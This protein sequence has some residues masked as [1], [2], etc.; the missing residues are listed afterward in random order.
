[1]YLV[2]AMYNG[3]LLGILEDADFSW[4][5]LDWMYSVH[6]V[7]YDFMDFDEIQFVVNPETPNKKLLELGLI[8]RS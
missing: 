7:Y 3:E 4:E 2:R 5:V 6:S 8:P 1:M